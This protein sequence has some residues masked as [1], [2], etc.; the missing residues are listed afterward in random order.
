MAISLVNNNRE[1]R[2]LVPGM[3]GLAGK[4]LHVLHYNDSITNTGNAELYPWYNGSL[5][6]HKLRH[7]M[8]NISE[9]LELPSAIHGIHA[10][11]FFTREPLHGV[12]RNECIQ[13]SAALMG[14]AS[15]SVNSSKLAAGRPHRRNCARGI[16]EQLC[17]LT[18]LEECAPYMAIG[19][20]SDLNIRLDILL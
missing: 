8:S 4:K 15:C 14:S 9:L 10:Y 2:F 16:R 19:Y 7:S 3:H 18:N 11:V 17:D 12:T 1:Y 5:T 13:S 20:S 6:I